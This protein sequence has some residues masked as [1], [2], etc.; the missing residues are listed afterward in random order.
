METQWKWDNIPYSQV[1]SE[2]GTAWPSN[3]RHSKPKTTLIQYSLNKCIF[4]EFYEQDSGV[5]EFYLHTLMERRFH[6]FSTNHWQE[7]P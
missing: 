3:T 6:I 4:L 1:D 5:L 7:S 2:R